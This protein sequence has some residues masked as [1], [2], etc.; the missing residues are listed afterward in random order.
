VQGFQRKSGGAGSVDRAVLTLSLAPALRQVTRRTPWD[1]IVHLDCTRGG[2]PDALHRAKNSLKCA[3]FL[4]DA[5]GSAGSPG[6]GVIIRATRHGL[7]TARGELCSN[8]W[9]H[10]TSETPACARSLSTLT[11][12]GS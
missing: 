12:V 8:F 10:G 6:G 2:A 7:R 1:G 5:G 4:R 9:L 3:I 11:R